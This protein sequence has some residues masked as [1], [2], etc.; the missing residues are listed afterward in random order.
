[1]DAVN[2]M[3]TGCISCLGLGGSLAGLWWG[4]MSLVAVMSV[5]TRKIHFKGPHAQ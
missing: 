3:G 2:D 5:E 1:M 4:M